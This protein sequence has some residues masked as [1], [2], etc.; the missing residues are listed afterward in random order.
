MTFQHSNKCSIK[1]YICILYVLSDKGYIYCNK[2][3]VRIS[4]LPTM[5]YNLKTIFPIAECRKSGQISRKQTSAFFQ[6]W[7]RYE[8]RLLLLQHV[9]HSESS[10]LGIYFSIFAIYWKVLSMFICLTLFK[11][12]FECY[13]NIFGKTYLSNFF[14]FNK[15]EGHHSYYL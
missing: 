4:S 11:F 5:Y 7:Y 14:L 13:R 12:Y 10:R 15:R 6:N 8:N 1:L 9:I 2:H 3:S